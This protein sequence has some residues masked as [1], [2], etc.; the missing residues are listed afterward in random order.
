M[1]QKAEP[2]ISEIIRDTLPLGRVFL[3]LP[4]RSGQL[5]SAHTEKT[6]SSQARR[7]ITSIL[8]SLATTLFLAP[9]PLS[10]YLFLA[11]Q[12]SETPIPSMTGFLL[13]DGSW[14]VDYCPLITLLTAPVF[15]DLGLLSEPIS[16]ALGSSL[17]IL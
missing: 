6:S 11:L 16:R 7:G 13:P 12:S 15:S 1:S 17:H 14:A 10:A 3:S 9:P 4:G 8:G 5:L 2:S